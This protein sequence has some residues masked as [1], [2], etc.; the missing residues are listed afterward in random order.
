MSGGRV[1]QCLRL[2]H[3]SDE[4]EV[5]VAQLT[6]ASTVQAGRRLEGRHRRLAG[7]GL[8]HRLGSGCVAS[9]ISWCSSGIRQ[10][11]GSN[12]SGIRSNALLLVDDVASPGTQAN[13]YARKLANTSELHDQQT[14][15]KG[16]PPHGL[17]WRTS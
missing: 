14:L 13:V 10:E 12:I 8:Q 11:E 5:L 6:F 16:D 4:R 15:P 2:D 17:T 1:P 9:V 3:H 7:E